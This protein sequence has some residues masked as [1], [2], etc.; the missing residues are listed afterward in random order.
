MIFGNERRID[1]HLYPVAFPFPDSK[2]LTIL[3]LPKLKRTLKTEWYKFDKEYN[4]KYALVSRMKLIN[5]IA[6]PIHILH[7][8]NKYV[9][10]DFKPDNVLV[11]STGKVTIVD[12]DSIQICE[13]GRLLFPG[14]AMADAAVGGEYNYQYADF[15]VMVD[16]ND[17]YVNFRYGPGL[18]YGIN[19]PIYNGEV[20]HIEATAD[21]YLDG[22]YWGHL[23][24]H[25]FF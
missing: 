1:P 3:I 24:L 15:Y 9:L 5:N 21:N 8:T 19:Y 13:N 11:T 23:F 6:I 16:A 10:K 4:I 22:L 17:G 18:E 20:L 7:S 14:T 25:V 12:M 2:K